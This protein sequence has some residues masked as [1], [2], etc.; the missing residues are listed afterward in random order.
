MIPIMRINEWVSMKKNQVIQIFKESIE[1][2]FKEYTFKK[3]DLELCL[4]SKECKI[5]Y[6]FRILNKYSSYELEIH[7]YYYLFKV[8]E[9]MKKIGESQVSFF[10][11]HTIKLYNVIFN[12]NFNNNWDYYEFQSSNI[13]ELKIEMS[14]LCSELKVIFNKL[15]ERIINILSIE[16]IEDLLRDYNKLRSEVLLSSTSVNYLVLYSA[17]LP[18][19]LIHVLKIFKEKLKNCPEETINNYNEVLKKL[20]SLNEINYDAFFVKKSFLSKISDI[21]K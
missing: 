1:E 12:K 11:Q 18:G 6:G 7:T 15:N 8:D 19:E 14:V 5:C 9:I 21:F 17:Y 16:S 20:G 3:S 4:I 10:C 2:N 13:A